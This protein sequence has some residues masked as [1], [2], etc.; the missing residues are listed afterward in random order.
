MLF[1]AGCEHVPR[2][3]GQGV[4]PGRPVGGDLP[5]LVVLAVPDDPRGERQAGFDVAGGHGG[6]RFPVDE[7][8]EGVVVT[9]PAVCVPVPDPS[10]KLFETDPAILEEGAFAQAGALLP[11]PRAD[12]YPLMTRSRRTAAEPVLAV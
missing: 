9:F 7:G 3:A 6:V 8:Q 12:G 4:E 5:R 11:D 1:P 10:G 2:P